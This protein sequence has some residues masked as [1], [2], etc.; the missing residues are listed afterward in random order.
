MSALPGAGC[1]ARYSSI[2]SWS[3]GER[4]KP[5]HGH[6]HGRQ[7][8]GRRLV[9]RPRARRRPP[10]H[11]KSWTREA[12]IASFRHTS[13]HAWM[14]AASNCEHGRLLGGSDNNASSS[15]NRR[16]RGSR[17]RS[18]HSGRGRHRPGRGLRLTQSTKEQPKAT[19][20][21][22]TPT[23]I[24]IAVIADVSTPLAP[25]LFKGAADAVQ[26]W[27]KYINAACGLAGRKGQV[28]FIDSK[29]SADE[30]RNAIIQVCQNDFV[31]VCMMAPSNNITDMVNCKD[32]AGKM[33]G[34]PDVPQLIMVP[35]DARRDV[36]PDAD[37]GGRR[38]R[39]EQHHVPREHL[40]LQV[41]RSRTS[42]RASTAPSVLRR[43]WKSTQT[44]GQGIAG[45]GVAGIKKDFQVRLGRHRP[46]GQVPAVRGSRSRPP[47]RR[48]LTV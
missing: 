10:A 21:G 17:T 48:S 43:I 11:P 13:G 39:Y 14:R 25:G 46:A 26:G 7:S 2:P 32:Q 5:A 36:V 35:D 30:T 6:P 38:D 16:V 37:P 42:T 20:V 23:T 4:S 40:Q 8:V 24:R 19:E 44:A 28:D 41:V 27:G 22:V 31:M 47:A 9:R 12:F 45:A 18:R 33:M 29:L 3:V 34:L 1:S 15:S